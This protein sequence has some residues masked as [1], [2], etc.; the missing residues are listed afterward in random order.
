MAPQQGSGI[1]VQEKGCAWMSPQRR[2]GAAWVNRSF[3]RIAHGLPLERTGH[4]HHDSR[5]TQK[6][7]NGERQRALRH[8]FHV[9]KHAVVDLLPAAD[10]VQVHDTDVARVVEIAFTGVDKRQVAIFPDTQRDQRRRLFRQEPLVPVGFHL[11]IRSIAS[12]LVERGQRHLVRQPL[13]KKTAERG[14]MRGGQGPAREGAASDIYIKWRV[15]GTDGLACGTIGW[16]GYPNAVPSTIRFATKLEPGVWFAPEW[17][18][19]WFPDAFQGTMGELL[20]S[21]TERRVPKI[22]GRDNL[23]TM[24]WVDACYRSLDEHRPVRIQ[25][26]VEEDQS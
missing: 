12:Q 19:V 20:N 4:G 7:G 16:P 9:L 5:S 11:E 2:C 8:F 17:P 24:A 15:E 18:E 13:A 25:E 26:I 6:K 3:Q 21:L 1:S 14:W 22:S 10:V 23:G